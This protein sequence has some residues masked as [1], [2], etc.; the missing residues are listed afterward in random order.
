MSLDNMIKFTNYETLEFIANKNPRQKLLDEIISDKFNGYP[1]NPEIDEK[2]EY[3]K[4]RLD[5]QSY[6]SDINVYLFP[7]SFFSHID[8]HKDYVDEFFGMLND[9]LDQDFE[10]ETEF[11]EFYENFF[12]FTLLA[13]FSDKPYIEVF[14]ELDRYISTNLYSDFESRDYVNSEIA[15]IFKSDNVSYKTHIDM[16]TEFLDKY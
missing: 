2:I 9:S 12:S 8:G 3:H 14:P 1:I 11:N 5:F 10:N 16:L 6:S 4:N 7:V 13:S 15:K